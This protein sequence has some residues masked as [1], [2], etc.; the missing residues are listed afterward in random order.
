MPGTIRMIVGFLTALGAMGTLEVD[1]TASVVSQ[2]LIALVGL[3]IAFSGVHAV[4]R[5]SSN[6]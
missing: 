3:A 2:T 5:S 6:G 1:P 4:N